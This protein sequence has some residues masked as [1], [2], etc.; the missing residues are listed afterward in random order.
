MINIFMKYLLM[1][2][3]TLMKNNL[4]I[5]IFSANFHQLILKEINAF[6]TIA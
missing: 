2:I 5:F 4:E 3:T 6:E 1:N